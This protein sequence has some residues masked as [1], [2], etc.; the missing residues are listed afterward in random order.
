MNSIGNYL[1]ISLPFAGLCRMWQMCRVIQSCIPDIGAAAAQPRYIF[2]FL[3][4]AASCRMF[5]A[6]QLPPAAGCLILKNLTGSLYL[7]HRPL[8]LKGKERLRK[9]CVILL[10]NQLKPGQVMFKYQPAA[11]HFFRRV[12]LMPS[13][14]RV[15]SNGSDLCCIPLSLHIR[16]ISYHKRYPFVYR[17]QANAISILRTSAKLAQI[18]H[19]LAIHRFLVVFTHMIKACPRKILHFICSAVLR[20]VQLFIASKCHNHKLIRRAHA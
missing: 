4:A 11:D 19:M 12:K 8:P 2:L 5:S 15:N 13:R 1:F 16:N 7:F 17:T 18:Q 9:K 14:R 20:Y 6:C 3:A 10:Q